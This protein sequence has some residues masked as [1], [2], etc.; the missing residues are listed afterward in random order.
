M[1]CSDCWYYVK[2]EDAEHDE[3]SHERS[4]TYT[5][6]VRED[7]KVRHYLC[8]VMLDHICVNHAYFKPNGVKE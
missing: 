7:S 2:K 6:G 5:L 1:K 8:T 4:G 3:C